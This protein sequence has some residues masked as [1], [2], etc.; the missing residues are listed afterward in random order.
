MTI[1]PL[2]SVDQ[3]TE[4]YEQQLAF[5]R[6]QQHLLSLAEIELQ[7]RAQ[8]GHAGAAGETAVTA[9]AQRVIVHLG[10]CGIAAGAREVMKTVL[11][12]IEARGVHDVLVTSTGCAGL[13][14]KE[15]MVTVEVQGQPPVKYV[16][17]DPEKMRR[18]FAEHVVGGALVKDYAL[19]A[20]SETTA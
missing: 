1:T 14:S 3:Q 2:R 7:R 11:D 8:Q 10:T 13:C 17:L 9:A 18:V 15:P 16:T 6:Q 12:E 5:V 20:G 19:A 4:E